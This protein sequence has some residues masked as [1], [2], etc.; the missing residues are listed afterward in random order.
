[1]PR[2][3]VRTMSQPIK[4]EIKINLIHVKILKLK[5]ISKMIRMQMNN[6]QIL[7]KSK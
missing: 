2:K 3:V 6:P 1:M 5:T 4:K 7:R